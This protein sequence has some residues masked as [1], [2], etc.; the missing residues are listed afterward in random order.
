MVIDRGA[1]LSKD[2]VKVF[3]EVA[4]IKKIC[5]NKTLKVIIESLSWGVMKILLSHHLYLCLPVLILS[6]PQPGRFQ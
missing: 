4:K 6:K 2:Y 5:G 1:L 3:N